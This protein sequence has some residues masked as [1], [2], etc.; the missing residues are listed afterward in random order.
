M[1][2]RLK[3][4]SVFVALLCCFAVFKLLTHALVLSSFS[5]MIVDAELDHEDRLE[6]FASPHARLQDYELV[7]GLDYGAGRRVTLKLPMN[8]HLARQVRLDLGQYAGTVRLYSL[9]FLSHFGGPVTFDAPAIQRAFRPN[10]DIA[11]VRLEGDALVLAT[12]GSDPFL[13]LLP[14]LQTRNFFIGWIL[15]LAHSFIFYLLLT[16]FHFRDFPAFRDIAGKVSSSGTNYGALDGMRGL[17]ALTVLGEHTG[18]FKGTGWLGILWFFTLS[19]FLLTLPFVQEPKRALSF[20]YMSNYIARRLRRV[21][22]MF[23]VVVTVLFLF[24]GRVVEAFRHYYLVQADGVLWTVPQELFFYFWL[25]FAMLVIGLACFARQKTWALLPLLGMMAF[26]CC[27]PGARPGSASMFDYVFWS[28]FLALLVVTCRFAG[29]KALAALFLLELSF[30]AFRYLTVHVISL[31][32]ENSSLPPKLGAFFCGS[33]FAY[34]S[35]LL[36]ERLEQEKGGRAPWMRFSA[37]G[38][39]LYVALLALSANDLLA[40]WGFNP[41]L[42]PGAFSLL[43]GLLILLAVFAGNSRFSA[44]VGCLPLRALGVVSFS[45]YL[46]HPLIL[47]AVKAANASLFNH[48]ALPGYAKFTVVGILTYIVAA[49]TYTYIE[50]PFVRR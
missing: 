49:L 16:R 50:R 42:Y 26:A 10:A 22:P 46:L 38:L 15:P 29:P 33:A 23:Y 34:L 13:T 36:A 31:Y 2:Q 5:Q 12:Q 17:A 9:T 19:G 7:G 32:G 25:P 45:F 11:S 20:D 40:P 3:S 8:D 24:R 4:V 28:L 6:L 1:S 48:M 21:L 18:V 43:S 39:L 27:L 35:S 30:I 37:A 47:Q 44:V 14:P 41:R